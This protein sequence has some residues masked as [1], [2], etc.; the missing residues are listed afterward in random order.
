PDPA[1][2]LFL[3]DYLRL[4]RGA[5]QRPL[6]PD[7]EEHLIAASKKVA[8]LKQSPAQYQE[9]WDPE[10]ESRLSR[11]KVALYERDGFQILRRKVGQAGTVRRPWLFVSPG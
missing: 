4:Y 9:E 5:G 8:C 7:A 2:E 10:T 1:F 3:A 6:F 11:S